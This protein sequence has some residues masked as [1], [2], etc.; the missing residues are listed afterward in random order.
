MFGI[1][2]D[3]QIGSGVCPKPDKAGRHAAGNTACGTVP[4]DFPRAFFC[5][6]G[7]PRRREANVNKQTL[8][9]F[10]GA[11]SSI[12]N[13]VLFVLKLWI[14]IATGSIAMIADAWHT[15]SDT[16]TSIIVI[17]GFWIGKKPG[18]A[19]HP[20]GHGRAELIGAIVISTLLAAVGVN[21]F[22]DSILRLKEGNGALFSG[23]AIVIFAV[24]AIIKESLAQFSIRAGKQIDSKALIADGWHHRSDAIA[25]V[26]IV[27]GAY[28]GKYAAW[29]DSALGIVVSLLILY[30]AFEILK[31]AGNRI[32]GEA[33]DKNMI[34]DID[35][36]VRRSAPD[37]VEPHHIHVHRYGDHLEATLH[38]FLPRP[39]SLEKA[40]SVADILE[41]R[42]R[43][44]LKIE[45]TIHIDPLEEKK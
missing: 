6:N 34:R 2:V 11:L 36:V 25:S 14:G 42:L 40:H 45:P 5:G 27:I 30:A 37:V 43:N 17:L 35:A 18:D 9:I 28:I 1:L 24:S 29:I 15:L 31:D 20:F 41:K 22:K 16:V 21:F 32:M 19:E 39:Y 3:T 8:G 23:T 7:F 10:E 38:I 33:A 4:Y 12:V 26:V 44:E 13:V